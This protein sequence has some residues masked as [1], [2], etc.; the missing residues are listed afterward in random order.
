VAKI[1]ERIL[2]LQERLSQLKA[3]QVR[4]EARKRAL[5]SRRARKDDTRRK[6]LAGAIVLTK[7]NAGDLD[8]KTFQ[9][10]L[11]QALIRDDDRALFELPP[12][13][14]AVPK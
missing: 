11:D 6:I 3:R 8:P 10:W 13:P 1:E 12:R 14:P 2:T 9:Q 4:A 7:V 5:L